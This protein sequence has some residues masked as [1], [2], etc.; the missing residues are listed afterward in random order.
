MRRAP[1]DKEVHGGDIVFVYELCTTTS[2][3][4]LPEYLFMS[5]KHQ[6]KCSKY[7]VT[8]S[9]KYLKFSILRS[10][11]REPCGMSIILIHRFTHIY[12]VNHHWSCWATN[13]ILNQCW[14]IVNWTPR[15]KFQW[16]LKQY[17]IKFIQNRRCENGGHFDLGLIV[18]KHPTST[19]RQFA[20]HRVV[21]T[22][23]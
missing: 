22:R 12:K 6:L 13:H 20:T 17:A 19:L 3:S 5:D 15:N 11:S 10:I 21:I 14:L 2:S 1:A 23:H 4:I 7:F 8:S 9:P 16:N 18:L